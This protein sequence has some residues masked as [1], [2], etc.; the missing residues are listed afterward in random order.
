MAKEKPQKSLMTILKKNSGRNNSG[1]ITTRHQG[2]RVKRFYRMIEFGE[3]KLGQFNVLSIQ[4]DPNRTCKIALIEQANK[5]RAYVLAPH[6]LKAGDTIEHNEKVGLAIGNR[7]KLKNFPV[8]ANVFNVELMPNKGGQI[9]RS[10]GASVAV[11]AQEG[12]YTTLKMPSS[13]T[14][15]VLSEC[16]ASFGSNSNPEHKFHQIGKAGTAR[17][18]GTRPTVR[19]SAMNACDHPHGGGKNKQ[20]IGRHPCTAWGKPALGVK[21]RK[22]KKLSNKFILQRRVKKKRSK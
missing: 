7:M 10:A 8:G 2:G 1:R 9:A 5:E 14:R 6:N 21:T 11:M 18:K 3:K 20:P 15:K 22:R 17:K 16:Y 13:E 12:K 4:Y 19:G